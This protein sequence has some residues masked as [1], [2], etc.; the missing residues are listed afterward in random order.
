MRL[1]EGQIGHPS[2][3]FPVDWFFPLNSS[4]IFT[5]PSLVICSRV[6]HSTRVRSWFW[7]MSE[8]SSD[9]VD[10]SF[11]FCFPPFCCFRAVELSSFFRFFCDGFPCCRRS[12]FLAEFLDCLFFS[13]RFF[14]KKTSPFVF[15]PLDEPGPPLF[16]LA[17]F[18]ARFN[19]PPASVTLEVTRVRLCWNLSS[20]NNESVRCDC[21][22]SFMSAS[23][24][25]NLSG[26]LISWSFSFAP[27]MSF[28]SSLVSVLVVNEFLLLQYPIFGRLN[29]RMFSLSTLSR[30]LSLPSGVSGGPGRFF[31]ISLF[32]VS[33]FRG[34]RLLLLFVLKKSLFPRSRSFFFW[35]RDWTAASTINRKSFFAASVR[36]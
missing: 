28:Y 34:R 36:S 12:F 27:L 7:K 2:L 9:L 23:L 24:S 13:S 32:G 33:F 17:H 29:L 19:P 15:G 1:L 30:K 18:F 5:F 21:S 8:M 25:S 11:F 35:V 3:V 4:A 6:L 20:A 14:F 10:R 22:C 26:E 31:K 16:G